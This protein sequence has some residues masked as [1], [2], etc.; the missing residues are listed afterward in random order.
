ML[1][2]LGFGGAQSQ[3]GL[4]KNYAVGTDRQLQP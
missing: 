2:D 4:T 3:A 1:S